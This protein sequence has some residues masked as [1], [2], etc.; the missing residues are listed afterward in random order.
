MTIWVLLVTRIATHMG[1][2]KK[3]VIYCKELTVNFAVVAIL[4]TGITLD[5][6]ISSVL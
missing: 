4:K 3:K 6:F 5:V 2:R 1:K